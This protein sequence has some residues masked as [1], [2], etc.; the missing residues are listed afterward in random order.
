LPD[1]QQIVKVCAAKQQACVIKS[2]G[3]KLG[4]FMQLCEAGF[5]EAVE[6]LKE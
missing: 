5:V 6:V 4:E 1:T 3:K 2:I